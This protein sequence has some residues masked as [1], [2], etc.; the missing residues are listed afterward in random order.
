MKR[1]PS[2]F[3]YVKAMDIGESVSFPSSKS[4]AARCAC[5]YLEAEYGWEFSITASPDGMS[6]V[7]ERIT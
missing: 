7:I 4:Y 6:V 1:E 3:S 2:T 5:S